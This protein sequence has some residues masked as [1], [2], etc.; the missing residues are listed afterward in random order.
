MLVARAL[1][2]VAAGA[3]T[4]VLV[5]VLLLL[6]LLA[7]CRYAREDTHYL[8]YIYDQLRLLLR[9]RRCPPRHSRASLWLF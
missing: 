8:L 4:L 9:Q 3:A 6:L 1:T 5:L 7:D 2:A